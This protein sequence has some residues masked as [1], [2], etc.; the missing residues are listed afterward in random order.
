MARRRPNVVC[1]SKLDFPSYRAA[2]QALKHQI[3]HADWNGK[4]RASLDVYRCST[5]HQ[6]HI[7][8]NDPKRAKASRPREKKKEPR[9]DRNAN[10]SAPGA[11]RRT[12]SKQRTKRMASIPTGL[13]DALNAALAAK[14]AADQA[15][16]SKAQ[17]DAALASAG[18]GAQ[19]AG[20]VLVSR[21]NELNATRV[22]LEAVEDAYLQPGA[23]LTPPAP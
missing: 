1:N 7:G 11:P 15:M 19:A 17:A 5:C 16:A 14:D 9:H 2:R 4:D 12:I 6:W 18:L 8:N 20:A 10:Y 23:V 21:V 3:Q 22:Q 13:S